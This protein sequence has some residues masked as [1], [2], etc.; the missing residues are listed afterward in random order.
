MINAI[1]RAR[2]RVQ[3]DPQFIDLID[4]NYH[5]CGFHYPT[6]T[7]AKRAADYF[8]NPAR[9]TY[10]PD[11]R[12]STE[13]RRGI[14]AYYRER[15]VRCT[16]EELLMTASSSES[17]SLLFTTLGRPGANVL[18]PRPTYPLFEDLAARAGL[19]VRYYQ[20]HE[21]NDWEADTKEIEQLM[22]AETA[23]VVLI[24][25]NNPTGNIASREVVERLL[26]LAATTSVP[27]VVDEV[28]CS[29]VFDP[30]ERPMVAPAA[31][32]LGAIPE[33]VV[34]TING[35]SKL[36]AAPDLKLSWMLISGP[37]PESSRLVHA[38]SVANDL[39]LNCSSLSQAVLPALFDQ[40]DD[41]TAQLSRPLTH[42]RN[43]L[44]ALCAGSDALS[45]HA[46]HGGIHAT[47]R[48]DPSI[49][50]LS[51]EELVV[52][53]LRRERVAVHPGYLYGIGERP[54]LIG[55]LLPSPER[56]AEGWARIAAFLS[57]F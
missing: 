28:F 41:V 16:E 31:V 19:R 22:D 33:A 21:E 1:A 25:P 14:C 15:G 35:A 56:F 51:D 18:L 8:S 38:L 9:H 43:H 13:A 50:P 2:A 34:I 39:Y 53:L 37:Q 45:L 20:Q 29:V 30:A 10:A 54:Y 24:S 4:T 36:F 7:V 17:Y 12:G 32:R 23:L 57:R 5:R 52:E 11:P 3:D 6:D 46:P 27:L 48:V 40:L 26:S 49:C 55:S 44:V 42:N 47:L